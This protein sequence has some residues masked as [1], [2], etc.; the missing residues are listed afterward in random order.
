[1]ATLQNA[2]IGFV[3]FGNMASAMADG[4][5]A[6]GEVDPKNMCACAGHFDALKERCATRGMTAYETADEVI[7]NA[8]V[9]VVGVKPYLIEKVFSGKEDALS[10]KIVLS[11]AW[12][13]DKGKWEAL[14]PGTHHIS[15]VPNIPVSVNAGVIAVE[16][17]STLNADEAKL[18][19][20][21]LELLGTPVELDGSLLWVGGT[22]AS[23]APA[24]IAV[25]TE[26]LADA[27]VKSGIPRADA[28]RIVSA[29]IAGTGKL[30]LE[31][32]MHPAALKDAVCSPGG[33]TIRGVAALEEAG[34]RN[35]LIKAIDAT[36][37]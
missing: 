20:G 2:K 10:G 11:I 27:A 33:A 6:S 32:G 15:T 31:T 34:L 22:T 19:G 23:C 24:F 35:A 18:I 17:Q 8:D 13:W 36:L 5:I 25:V 7:A 9:I 28:Y 26:A 12:T 16:K 4:W 3:G 21:L 29:M 30:Q 37:K 1:M 14:L